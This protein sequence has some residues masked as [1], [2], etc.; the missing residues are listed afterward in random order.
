MIRREASR[1][2]D[3][4][5]IALAFPLQ[6]PAR[7]HAIEISVNVYFEQRR[8]TVRWPA[9]RQRL[10]P[11]KPE[12]RQIQAIHER[13]DR[14]NRIVIADGLIK[15]GREQRALTAI[16]ALDEPCH[17]LAPRRFSWES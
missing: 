2:P 11:V 10:H 17:C 15:D 4:L 5:D 8:W 7:W 12:R 16:H 13:I 9:E 14:T 6:A 3:E 1:Q